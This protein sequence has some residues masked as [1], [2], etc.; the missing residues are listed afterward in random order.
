MAYRGRVKEINRQRNE[1]A[2]REKRQRDTQI[3][4]QINEKAKRKRDK[5]T[6]RRTDR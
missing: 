1:K 3:V 2:N 4:R 6:H 5:E